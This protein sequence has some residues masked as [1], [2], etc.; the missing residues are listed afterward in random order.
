MGTLSESG[1]CKAFYCYALQKSMSK[2]VI[3]P[4]QV[5]TLS[6]VLKSEVLEMHKHFT[7]PS[8]AVKEVF[9]F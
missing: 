5:N 7:A 2:T 9:K 1:L 8:A 3:T 6:E 4:Q